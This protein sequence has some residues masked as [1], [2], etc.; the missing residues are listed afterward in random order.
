MKD[1]YAELLDHIEHPITSG[2]MDEINEAL[3]VAERLPTLLAKMEAAGLNVAG[4]RE[5]TDEQA[6]ILR[7]LRDVF[8]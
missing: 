1:D 7:G 8:G 3:Q 4:L 2:Q 5:R 6:A